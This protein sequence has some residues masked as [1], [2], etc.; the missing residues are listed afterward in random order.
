MARCVHIPL[1]ILLALAAAAPSAASAEAARAGVAGGVVGDVTVAGD[2]RPASERATSGSALYALDNIS[3]GD[4]SRM[5]ALL[6]D[7]TALTLGPNSK[8]V[9]DRFI[10]DPDKGAGAM[11]ANFLKGSMRF[12]SGRTSAIARSNVQIK[13]PAGTLGVRGTSAIMVETTPGEEYFVGLL[14]PG[15]ENNI[16]AP[17]S[18]ITF[19]NDLGGRTINQAGIGFF[20]KVGEAPGPLVVIPDAIRDFLSRPLKGDPSQPNQTGKSDGTSSETGEIVGGQA[21]SD[22]GQTTATLQGTA[23]D[24]RVDQSSALLQE[25][26]DQ[27]QLQA[28]LDL[29]QTETGNFNVDLAAFIEFDWRD[30]ALRDLDAHLT[31]PEDEGGR[32][33]VFF[34]N[35]GSLVGAPFAA[36]DQDCTSASCSEVITVQKFVQ[37]GVYRASLLTDGNQAATGTDFS[38][39]SGAITM[40]VFQNGTI[41]R[42]AQGGSSIINGTPQLTVRP[43]EVGAGNTWVAAELNPATGVIDAVNTIVNSANSGAVQ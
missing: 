29:A 5:Q 10:Y 2:A 7:E 43:P 24:L 11:V 37:G 3:T 12:V 13:T 35:R 36:L 39:N 19:N 21:E 16:G 20:A 15:Q 8:V 17:A 31:G 27:A 40:K 26:T 18:Q 1:G 6:L 42:D 33:H 32:F 23:N 14:G 28:I 30:S 25:G 34:S 4:E 38:E 22:S 9:I 41:A